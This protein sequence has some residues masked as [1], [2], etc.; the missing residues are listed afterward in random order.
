MTSNADGA[1]AGGPRKGFRT[2]D[3]LIYVGMFTVACW[4]TYALLPLGVFVTVILLIAFL[5][6]V[7]RQHRD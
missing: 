4:L 5:Q 7:W 2:T 6:D 3:K 1:A